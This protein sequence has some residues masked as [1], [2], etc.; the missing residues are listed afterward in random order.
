[1]ELVRPITRL[2]VL[3]W[4]AKNYKKKL[5]KCLLIAKN[6][7]HYEIATHSYNFTEMLWKKDPDEWQNDDGYIYTN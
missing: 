6:K 4:A 1:M 7:K 3:L 2:L 5:K